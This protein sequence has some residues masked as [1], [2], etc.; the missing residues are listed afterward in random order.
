MKQTAALPANLSGTVYIRVK[1]TDPNTTGNNVQD[2]LSVD[3]LALSVAPPNFAPVVADSTVALSESVSIGSSVVTID[4]GDPNGLDTHTYAITAG[5]GSGAFDIDSSGTITTVTALDYETTAQYTLTVEV[6]DQGSLSDTATITVNVTDVV[7][8]PVAQN[9]TLVLNANDASTAGLVLSNDTANSAQGSTVLGVVSSAALY[10][11]GTS[12][13]PT[14]PSTQGWTESDSESDGDASIGITTGLTSINDNGSG[15]DAWV[16]TDNNGGGGFV[17]YTATPTA[18]QTTSGTNNGWLLE[19]TMRLVDDFNSAASTVLI[20]GNGSQRFVVFYDLDANDDLTAE[21]VGTGGGTY[22][23]TSGGTGA[24]AFHDIALSYDA[25][26]NTA[27]FFVDGVRHD[28]GAWAGDVNVFNGL[29]FG[30]GSTPGRGS[31]AF[32]KVQL[33]IFENPA[34]L[35][36]GASVQI[37]GNDLVF[38][39]NGVYDNLGSGESENESVTYAVSNGT[40]LIGTA[41]FDVTIN[42]VDDPPAFDSDPVVAPN[43][44]FENSYSGTLADFGGDPD[45]NDASIFSKVDGPSWLSIA[46]DGTFSGTPTAADVG[47]NSFTV[48]VGDGMGNSAQTTL[49]ITVEAS[50]TLLDDDFE[51]NAGSTLAGGWVEQIGDSRIYD[52]TDTATKMVIS[53]LSGNRYAIMNPLTATF[54]DGGRYKLTWNGARAAAADGTLNYDVSVGTWDGTTFTPLASQTGNI[55]TV[56]I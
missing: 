11:A 54:E 33:S 35:A 42:G 5:N 25:T 15:L 31:A 7:E 18:A 2:T 52:T 29:Q 17:T 38:N 43:G 41:S 53:V 46:T 55:A 32:H 6:T 30:N 37:T 13:S 50:I 40:G 34:T 3:Y 26:S 47:L 36:S 14:N 27:A 8:A 21:L 39:T 10:D 51:R 20:Y 19:T 4:A 24:A 48:E 44:V 23:L 22:T 16:V 9:D 28:T 49:E 45:T 56:N 12:G 1:D